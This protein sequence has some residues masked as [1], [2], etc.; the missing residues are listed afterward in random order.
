MHNEAENVARPK[1]RKGFSLRV[2]IA[3]SF[4]SLL[5]LIC[6]VL[7]WY[8]YDRN[9]RLVFQFADSFLDAATISTIDNTVYLLEPVR[10]AV[11]ELAVIGEMH[12]DLLEQPDMLR[13]LLK[14]LE[15]YPHVYG[16]YI[17]FEDSGRFIQA[18]RIP[19]GATTFGPNSQRISPGTRFALRVV[20]PTEEGITDNYTFIARWGTITGRDQVRGITYD[21]RKRPFYAGAVQRG[22]PYLSDI[23]VFASNRKPGITI[24]EPFFGKDGKLIGVVAADITLDSMSAFLKRQ[25]IGQAGIAF[26]VDEQEQVV[27]F[28]DPGKSVRQDGLTVSLPTIED[29]D[30]PYVSEAFRRKHEGAGDHFIYSWRG[31]D[32]LASFQSF[33]PT[34]EKKWSIAIL[35]PVNDFVGSLKDT[36]RD[37]VL[38][39]IVVSILAILAINW[40]ARRITRPIQQVIGETDR[41]RKFKLKGEV[42]VTS[43]ITEIIELVDAMKAMK[44]AIQ[45]FSRFVPRTLVQQLLA[46]GRSLELGGQTQRLTIMFSDLAS[47]SRLSERL[48]ARDLMLQISQHLDLVSKVVIENH[49]TIDKFIGDATMAFWGAPLTQPDHASLAC[50]SALQI[51]AQMR[52][53]NEQAERDGLPVMNARIGL[54]TD[55]VVVGNIGS[56]ERMS[57]TAIGDGVNIASRLEGINK[58][59]GTD[60]C[61][62]DAVFRETGDRF[63]MRPID[64][65]AV[66]GRRTGITIYELM[67]VREEDSPLSATAAQR[68]LAARTTKGFF[69]Y[70]ERKWEKAYKTYSTAAELYPQDRIVARFAERCRQLLDAP[71]G[72]NWSGVVELSE[73]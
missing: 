24:S 53:L 29:L 21:P 33:P 55:T 49:G 46:S 57:Y 71:P 66:K 60:I 13:H 44:A 43:R 34:F 35:V 7:T 32:Y 68:D 1:R 39:S 61:V 40:V 30:L 26:I 11:G 16:A 6:A 25:R 17:G 38:I 56:S 62:S 45:T 65:V 20:E 63:L 27:A 10:A 51:Q 18:L 69:A 19:A 41:I 72:P 8:T 52:Q 31:V 73:K 47:F 9:S 12:P 58:M 67:A 36:T 15:S 42:N 23:Y 2:S 5:I 50:L 70:M 22:G 54:H 64:H 48:P 3:T 14:V 28:P 37:I 59:Y 4:V